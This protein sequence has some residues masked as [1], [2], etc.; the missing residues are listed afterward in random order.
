LLRRESASWWLDAAVVFLLAAALVFPLFF[1]DYSDKWASIESTFISDA[2]FLRDHWPH[3]L[4]QP[5]WYTGTRF[6]YIYPPALRYGT[7]AL[8]KLRP[9]WTTARS[10]HVY[11]ALFYCLGIAGVYLLA[12]MGGRSRRF[13]IIAALL[14][15]TLSPSFLFFPEIRADARGSWSEPQRLGVLHRYGEGPHMSAVAMLGFALAFSISALNTGR[16]RAIAAAAIACALVVS[17]NF[18][19]ATALA[20]LFPIVLWSWWVTHL[21]NRIFLRAAAII[22][23][24]VGLCAFWLVPS[25]LSVTLDN[26]RFVSERGNRWS[27]WVTVGLVILFLKFSE[28]YARGLKHRAYSVFLAGALV[29]FFLNVV[30]NYFWKFRVIGEPGRMMPELDLIIILAAVELLRRLWIAAS[31][32]FLIPRRVLVATVILLLFYADRRYIRNSHKIFVSDP[33]PQARMEYQITAWIAQHMPDAR[34]YTTGTARF[35]Y[36]AW[37]DLAQLGGGSEQGLINPVV[38]PATWHLGLSED[39]IVSL[40]WLQATGV[41][42]AVVHDKSSKEHYHDIQYPEKFA[43]SMTAVYNDGQ[44]NFVY[45]VPRRYPGIARVVDTERLDALPPL[46][47]D[48]TINQLRELVDILEHGPAAPTTTKWLTNDQLRITATLQ[49]GQTLF[50]QSAFDPYF[51]ATSNG[52]EL[53]ISRTAFNFTRIDAPPGTHEILMTFSQPIENRAGIVIFWITASSLLWLCRR[54]GRTI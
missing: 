9:H 10:Y 26:M 48:P 22:A 51:R 39:P 30:G 52:N 49:P 37:H 17:N 20:M 4:W 13:A 43:K 11:V 38:Q 47:E 7:A 29:I 34:T 41:D 2:R 18:Y 40:L 42:A 27:I 46:P 24:S 6:D 50:V 35:W 19:G 33:A 25:Y 36:N 14:V 16:F 5:L 21:D 12:R 54:P 45:Q 32:R 28:K 44:G 1:L 53:P 8:A 15:A 31:P 3:P 23:A